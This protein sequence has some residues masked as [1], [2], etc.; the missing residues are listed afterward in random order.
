MNKSKKKIVLKVLICS[1]AHRLTPSL[2][3]GKL[4]IHVC[5]VMHT[6]GKDI[7]ENQQQLHLA[8]SRHIGFYVFTEFLIICE[9]VYGGLICPLNAHSF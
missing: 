8:A 1:E 9:K 6:C 7:N 4:V 5:S 2:S 3:F